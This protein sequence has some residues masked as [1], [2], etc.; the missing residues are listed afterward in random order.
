[1]ET[2]QEAVKAMDAVVPD[3][4]VRVVRRIEIGSAIQQGDVYLF[5]VPDNHPK[6]KQIGKGKKQIAVGTH[7]GARHVVEGSVLVYEGV[8]LPEGVKPPMDVEAREICGP[9][10]VAEDAFSLVHPEHAHHQLPAGTYQTTYQLDLRTMKRV[11]D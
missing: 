3:T 7:T 1:M 6:G 5:R 9:V 8:A 11:V 10:I 4:E 2:V